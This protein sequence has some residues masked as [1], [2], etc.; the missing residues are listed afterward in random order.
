MGL[1]MYL[2]KV[3]RVDG[4]TVED[5]RYLN[6]YFGWRRRPAKYRK[7]TMKDWCGLEHRDIPRELI[8]AYRP[9]YIHRYSEWDTEKK[10]GYST[11]F[12]KAAQWRKANQIHNWFVENVQN[13]EDDCGLYEVTKEQLQA[14]L[15]D[16]LAVK[17]ASKLVEGNVLNGYS[18]KD[19][20][21]IRNEEHGYVIEDPSVAEDLLPTT[22]GFF[23]GSTDYDQWYMQDIDYTVEKLTA[24]LKDDDFDN[25][26]FA[27]SSSW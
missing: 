6:E 12:E 1:D 17:K 22:S 7:S 2:D 25:W 14:L 20:K 27:Y 9:E 19:G 4:A 5:V 15:A 8:R 18:F 21:M 10:Y 16:C 24:I 26:M 23:F 13:G 11:L 3:K